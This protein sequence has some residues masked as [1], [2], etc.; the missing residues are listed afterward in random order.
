[1]ITTK[2]ID[3]KKKTITI[4]F[5]PDNDGNNGYLDTRNYNEAF[6]ISLL[7]GFYNP[8][9]PYSNGSPINIEGL[10]VQ[11]QKFENLIFETMCLMNPI[12]IH[13]EKIKG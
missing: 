1:M 13:E 3:V 2:S 12:A 10:K 6:A 9:R 11:K 8:L 7:T 5:E 4:V